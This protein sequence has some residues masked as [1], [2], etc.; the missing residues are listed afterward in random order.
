MRGECLVT[1]GSD[2]ANGWGPFEAELFLQ[3]TDG[4]VLRLAHHRSTSCGYWVQPRA[5]VSRDGRYVVFASDWG[6][7]TGRSGCSGGDD[8]GRGD[9]YIIDL[10]GGRANTPP[11][12]APDRYSASQGATLTISAPGVLANDT[13]SDGDPLT[14]RL[15]NGPSRGNLM[16]N[17]DGSFAYTP[18]AGFT[19]A[20]SFTYTANDSAAQSNTA[21]VTITVSPF[22][23]CLQDDASGDAL[24]MNST[25]GDYRFTACGASFTLSGTGRVK[26]KK[27]GCVISLK[28]SRSDR[29]VKASFNRCRNKGS[30]AVAAQGRTFH[31]TDSRTTDNACAC[32]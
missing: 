30:A 19:G 8:L 11:V 12:A 16:L 2:P 6:R 13:D 29:D 27:K 17:A 5:S 3:R 23:V 25:T 1:A 31:I 10:M 22:D 14:A 18:D 7:E 21:T 32:P 28:D 15:M 4:T 20:D 26:L 9:V 24:M